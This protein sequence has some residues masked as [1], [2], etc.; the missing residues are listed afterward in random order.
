[1][2]FTPPLADAPWW[3]PVLFVVVMGHI[4]N[5]CITL[6]LHRSATHGGVKFHPI[7]EHFMRFWLWLTTGV[8]T[9]EW[10]AVH[11]KHHAFS[12]REGDPHSPHEEG[13]AAILFGGLFFYREAAKDQELLDK[14]GKGCPE[15]WVER[16]VYSRF[17][18][19]GILSM[20]VVDMLLFGPLVGL[21]VWAGMA[22]WLPTFGQIINAIGH[23]LGYR[24]FDTKDHS[25]NIYPFGIWIVGEE[26]HNNHHADPRSAKFQA[27]WWEFDIGWMYIKL[28]S[29]VKLADVVYA[30]SASVKEFASKYY[31]KSGVPEQI[32]DVRTRFDEA[33]NEARRE[34]DNARERVERLMAEART[35]SG[36]ARARL[37]A[38]AVDARAAVDRA[39]R[40]VEEVVT[41]ARE[42]AGEAGERMSGRA[43][44]RERS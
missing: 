29:F 7:S 38:A 22:L 20:L 36:D 13:L 24:N 1:M 44:G 31:E 3:V 27:H 9:K 42:A 21:L 15:D 37:E 28:L 10:V 32:E 26:L 43:L 18:A 41:E 11:R 33:L 14:Y 2:P 40:R 34:L 30:R 5:V 16:N 35:A 12:D 23:A 39:R 19:V 4:T 8:V 6:Y 25:H 17:N